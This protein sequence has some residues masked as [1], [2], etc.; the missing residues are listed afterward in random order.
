M[1]MMS[2]SR[3]TSVSTEGISARAPL[4][5]SSSSTDADGHLHLQPQPQQPKPGPIHFLDE[6]EKRFFDMKREHFEK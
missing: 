6:G 3:I 1:K 5:R 2:K 4:R